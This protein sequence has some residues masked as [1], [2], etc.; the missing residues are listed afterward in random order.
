MH[1][2]FRLWREEVIM[3]TFFFAGF[4]PAILLGCSTAEHSTRPLHNAGNAARPP[5][6][7]IA[8]NL[9]L[10][11]AD[12]LHK[13]YDALALAGVR[14]GN[15]AMSLDTE[16]VVVEEADFDRGKSIATGIVVRDKLTVRIYQSAGPVAAP[17]R[18]EVWENGQKVREE[19]YKLYLEHN[20]SSPERELRQRIEAFQNDGLELMLGQ[21]VTIGTPDTAYVLEH[22]E[23]AKPLLIEALRDTAHLRKVGFAAYC[24]RIMKDPSGRKQAEQALDRLNQPRNTDE[25]FAR[26]ELKWYLKD[27]TSL[28]GYWHHSPPVA[29]LQHSLRTGMSGDDF[30]KL[31]GLLD[32][33][34]FSM[35]TAH[36]NLPDGRLDARFGRNGSL[37]WWHIEA[38]SAPAAGLD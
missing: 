7:D 3:K 34:F 33:P 28:N 36:Y 30:D 18:L 35:M 12:D 5:C 22:R 14:C 9:G 4:L 8:A 6:V 24:L 10:K 16:Q 19:P 27:V 37:E 26:N 21:A 31:V 11:H 20:S 1:V 38:L 17:M 32:P 2:I 15:R 29:D 13:L 23:A 25:S